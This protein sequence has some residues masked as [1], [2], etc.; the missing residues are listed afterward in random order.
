M[1]K[2]LNP[3][4]KIFDRFTTEGLEYLPTGVK[5][6]IILCGHNRIGYSVL[7]NL[8]K[9]KKKILVIDYNPEVISKMVKEGY[10][11]IYGEVTD[12]EI[13]ERMNLKKITMLISTVPRFEDSSFL[14][15]K[16]REVNKRAKVLVT[17]NTIEEAFKLYEH[18]ADYVILPHF[19]GG[20]HA[21]NLISDFRSKKVKLKE[22]KKKH[23]EFLKKR[24]DMGHEHPKSDE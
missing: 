16:V 23:I 3:V 18:G 11:C 2:F 9:L 24:R 19:L 8:H 21:S 4:L 13:I 7:Q 5:P 17:A 22:E 6:K 10:H 12:E 14:L 20:E 1:Y 15:K